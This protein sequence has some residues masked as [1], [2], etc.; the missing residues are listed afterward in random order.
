MFN[1]H[2]SLKGDRLEVSGQAVE[3]LREKGVDPGEWI[4]A[5]RKL[6]CAAPDDCRLEIIAFRSPGGEPIGSIV[7]FP[8]HAVIASSVWVGNSLYPDFIAGLRAVYESEVGGRVLFVQGPMA[9]VKPLNQEYGF[10]P[11][12]QYGRRLGKEAVKLAERMEFSPLDLVHAK[13]HLTQLPLR[14][15]YMLA[16]QQRR[17]QREQLRRR[18]DRSGSADERLKALRKAEVLTWV[19]HFLIAKGTIVTPDMVRAEAMPATV[20]AFRFNDAYLAALPGEIFQSTGRKLLGRTGLDRLMI[21]ELAEEYVI[22]VSPVEEYGSG[23]Y[24]DTSCCLA[25]GADEMLVD[26]AA[27]LLAEL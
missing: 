2:C 16:E 9:D 10:E 24:E 18:A 6:Y 5:D 12:M 19:D 13:S 15:E 11:A 3:Y 1:E 27:G 25:A 14:Q 4:D 8:A 21:A 7:R 17:Q 20:G 23:G 26:A 22:Y